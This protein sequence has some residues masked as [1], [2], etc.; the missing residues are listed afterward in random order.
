MPVAYLY[1]GV[2]ILL[3]TP[4]IFVHVLCTVVTGKY[5]GIMPDNGQRWRYQQAEGGMALSC[6]AMLWY[7]AQILGIMVTFCATYPLV[8]LIAHMPWIAGTGA[9]LVLKTRHLM[10]L[11]EQVRKL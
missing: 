8:G 9:V 2:M 7:M 3:M 1:F 5:P 11:V 10:R 6:L 4:L